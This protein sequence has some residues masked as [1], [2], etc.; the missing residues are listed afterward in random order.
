M[1]ILKHSIALLFALLATGA[2]ADDA[3]ICKVV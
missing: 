3:Q 1:M 2:L